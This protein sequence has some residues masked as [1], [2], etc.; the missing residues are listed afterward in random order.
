MIVSFSPD[1]KVHFFISEQFVSQ[2]E[3][4]PAEVRTNKEQQGSHLFH[5]DKD[6]AANEDIYNL[7]KSSQKKQTFHSLRTRQ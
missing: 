5:L 7:N 6:T 4:S 3:C 2:P 1:L